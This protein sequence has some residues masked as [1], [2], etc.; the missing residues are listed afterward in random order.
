LS[1]IFK[2]ISR[3]A[4]TKN[5]RKNFFACLRSIFF[6]RAAQRKNFSQPQTK[7]NALRENFLKN[8]RQKGVRFSADASL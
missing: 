2:K 3:S 1:S 8:F 6:R 4:F 5:N 7:R